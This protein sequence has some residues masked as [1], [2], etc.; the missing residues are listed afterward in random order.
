MISVH[1]LTKRY[2]QDTAVHDLSFEVAEGQTLALVGT[3]G[4]G[5]T[6][7]LKMINRLVEPSSG[8]IILNGSNIMQEPV[9]EVRRRMGYVIQSIGLFPHYTVAENVGV[10]PKLL[11]WSE[12]KIRKRTDDLLGRLK[13]SPGK[14][15]DKYPNQLSG[16]QRQRVGIAR[17]LAANPPIILMDEP[18]GALD[19][20]TRKDIQKDFK[21]LEELSEK[22]TILVTHDVEEAFKLADLIC[23][24][25]RGEVQQIG[26]PADLLF[27]PANDFIRRFLAGQSLQLMFEVF[28]LRDLAPM[29]PEGKQGHAFHAE[30]R[31]EKVL[32][33]LTR[34]DRRT[35]RGYFEVGS[36]YRT[37]SWQEMMNAIHQKIKIDVQ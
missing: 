3:S 22:T 19:P 24:L 35:E 37:F 18:F 20:I 1:H 5:K 34:P 25:D 6:T 2:G 13:L 14:Y 21:N 26:T 9:V 32:E 23:V 12:K 30:D 28:R 10:T 29:L 16:G 31:L 11:G 15:L 7:T 8:S 33:Q 4:C 36:S 17:A 27:R